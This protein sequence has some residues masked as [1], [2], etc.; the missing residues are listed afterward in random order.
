MKCVGI[1][2]TP[3]SE[4]TFEKWQQLVHPDD[5]KRAESH[6]GE[7]LK[8]DGDKLD[9]EFR[10]KHAD[11]HWL[12]VACRGQ[13]VAWNEHGN[14]IRML[15]LH[16]DISERK[17]WEHEIRARE[18]LL[19]Q[20]TEQVPGLLYQFVQQPDGHMYFPF[21]SAHI[22]E[23][24]GVTPQ[25]AE[26]DAW[27]AASNI[28]PDDL[29]E[30][31]ASIQR[32]G[33]SLQL[34]R[35][36]YRVI[37]PGKGERWIR[38]EARPER[39]KDG[40]VL[41]HGYIMDVTA[42]REAERELRLASSVF[43]HT[44]EGIMITDRTGKIIEV[45]PT[46]TRITGYRRDDVM[47]E[48]PRLL[49]SG[50]HSTEFFSEMWQNLIEFGFWQGEVWNKRK[51]GQIY[52]ERKT[53]SAVYDDH[54]NIEQFVSLFSDITQLKH[55]QQKLEQLA[56]YDPLTSLPNR[57]LLNDRLYMAVEAAKRNGSQ[58]SVVYVDLDDFKP[59]NDQFGHATG[60]RLLEIIAER[61]VKNVR[62]SDTVAR[63][64][65]DEFI[66]LLNH[67]SVT[68]YQALI[69]RLQKSL[70]QPVDIENHRVAVSSSIG[71]AHF[72]QD[73]ENAELLIRYADRAM[74]AAKQSGK[75]KAQEYNELGGV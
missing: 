52:C 75:N 29:D 31:L 37:L 36:Q 14:P 34:W 47:G 19:K 35:K 1:A 10:F 70:Q 53:I 58:L 25:Q 49:A 3:E 71:I 65:G 9:I 45:N 23:I 6:I 32:S 11:G 46:F 63:I 13:V 2:P 12:W 24:Y 33:E 57:T 51:N 26:E 8:I 22:L 68:G 62:K 48:D 44:H 64:G 66:L 42:E 15:G 60:D 18:R 16:T 27:H 73:A 39:Q 28:H 43:K 41:W 59:V 67:E 50:R 72:P 61:L 40:S 55:Q 38:G 30:V 7:A 5:L 4:I 56:H 21:A 20:L 54:G 17:D 74:Y 69:K